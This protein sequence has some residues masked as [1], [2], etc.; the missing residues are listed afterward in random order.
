MKIGIMTIYRSGNYG[1][2]LQSYA[3]KQAINENGFGEAEIIPYCSD[4]IKQKLN[5]AYIKKAGLFQTAVAC[6]EKIYYHPRMKKVNGFIDSFATDRQLNREELPALNDRYDIFLSGSDQIWNPDLQQGDASYLLDFV[7]DPRKKRSY[8]SSFGVSRIPEE[9]LPL[10]QRL[11]SEYQQITVRE[12]RGIE[13]VKELSGK[14]AKLVI[15]PALLLTP[16]QWEAKL[17]PSRFK[18]D[19]VFAYQMAHSP[20]VG[21]V[22]SKARKAF[23]AKAIFVPFPIMGVCRCR[24]VLSISSLEWVRAI[25]ESKF[26]VTD[27]FHGVVFS[28][29]FKKQFY[30]VITSDTIK[31]RL[32]RLE[33]LL[34]SLGIEDR[35]V[36]NAAACDFSKTID[37]DKVHAL[38]DEQR[39]RSLNI[40]KELVS[41]DNK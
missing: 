26:V 14:E 16:A 11:L 17:P 38:L 35:F 37:Y 9:Y 40:L 2:T 24:P 4:A 7:T 28:I 5:L 29:I 25:K 20:L 21:Q 13:L 36:E 22:M 6:V 34:S 33:T 10:Y 1:A 31:K 23:C 3:T 30:Y 27:S 12:Q 19:Y 18:G 8:A 32:S 15:D 41:D 39:E